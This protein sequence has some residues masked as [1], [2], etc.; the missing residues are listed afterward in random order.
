MKLSLNLQARFALVFA[1]LI[2]VLTI[3]ISLAIGWQSSDYVRKAIG[4]SLAETAYHTADQLDQYMWARNSEITILSELETLRRLDNSK[5][6][7]LLLNGLKKSI[8][9]FSWVGLTD[10]DGLVLAG[11]DGILQGASLGKRPVYLEGRN[12]PFVGDVH[13]AVL[14]A[15]LL[16]NPSGEPMKFVDISTPIMDYNGQFIGVLAA[17]LSWDWVSEVRASIMDPLKDRKELEIFIVSSRDNTI[18]LGP[19]EMIGQPLTVQSVNFA[20]QGNNNWSIERWPDGQEYL[21][22]YALGTG[23]MNYKG[24][25]WSVL[26]RQP[27]EIAF[28]PLRQLQL[29]ILLIGSI[30]ALIFAWFGWLMAGSLSRPLREITKAADKLRFGEK[31][32]IPELKGIEEIE[33][34][35]SSFRSLIDSLSETEGELGKMAL[36]AHN[37]RLTGLAN[38][39]GLDKFLEISTAT[40]NRRQLQLVFLYLDLDGFKNVNDTMGHPAGDLLLKEVAL[41]LKNS[42]RQDEMAARLGGDEFLIVLYAEPSEGYELAQTIATRIINSINVPFLIE[43]KAAKVGCS[44]GAAVWP[45]DS[46]DINATIKLADT[47]L[48]QAKNT[49]KNKAVFTKDLL[50]N[51]AIS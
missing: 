2:M 48:Y 13:D 35:T 50:I 14:L 7:E 24:L 31:V 4:N 26:V 9:A 29:L 22:G 40:A 30:S 8:P 23:H 5:N 25:G 32:Q 16:P 44:I 34:L 51:D 12:G 49:G 15:K 47:A 20:K 43:G 46:K 21:T 6:V 38:R 41:R 11:T 18:L 33:I 37:D 10:K 28:A 45:I 27:I 1:V 36:L 3:I 17:H 39:I 42:V 19:K